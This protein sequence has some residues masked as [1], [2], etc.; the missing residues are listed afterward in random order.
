[1][2]KTPTGPKPF[3]IR[4]DKID[5]FIIFLD[6][7]IKHLILFA[8]GLFN[9]I[10]DEIKYLVSKKSGIKNS[11]N[12]NFGKIRT[13]FYNSLPIKNILTFHDVITLIKSVVNKNKN[14]YYYDIFLEK[15]LHKDK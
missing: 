5:E 6:G 9:E 7:K 11:V 14:K 13:D 2:Y 10:C 4:F 3:R 12:H 8:F 15:G 1:M